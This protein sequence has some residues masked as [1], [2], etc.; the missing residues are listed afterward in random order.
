MI[1]I[2]IPFASLDASKDLFDLTLVVLSKGSNRK[3]VGSIVTYEIYQEHSAMLTK[4][5]WQLLAATGCSVDNLGLW[6]EITSKDDNVP[7]EIAGATYE[8][9]D[10]N[11]IQRSWS[12]WSEAYNKPFVERDTRTFIGVYGGGTG[13]LLANLLPLWAD[14]YPKQDLPP[15][16]ETPEA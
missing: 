3:A 14:I 13:Q 11:T 6:L 10:G 4:D 16:D 5:I 15:A 9:E 7:S 2:N 1:K 12:A 8:D